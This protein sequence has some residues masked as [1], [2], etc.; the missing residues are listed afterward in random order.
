MPEL[1]TSSPFMHHARLAATTLKQFSEMSSIPYVKVVA[2]VSLLILE[3]VVSVKANKEECVAMIEKI[4]ELLSIVIELCVDTSVPLSPTLIEAM[5]NF[6]ET[7]QKIQSFMRTQQD[8]GKFKR[9]F[10]AT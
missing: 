4:D 6:A 3:T 2:G 1:A 9:F 10:S 5:G 8:M 7:L